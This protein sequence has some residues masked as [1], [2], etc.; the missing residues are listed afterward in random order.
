MESDMKKVGVLAA[1][2]LAEIGFV[3]DLEAFFNSVVKLLEN[4]TAGSV[5]PWVTEKLYRR[6]LKENELILVKQQL[7]E[8]HDIF[9]SSKPSNVNLVDMGLV[10]ENTTFDM[11]AKNLSTLFKRVFEAYAEA[12]ECSV[13]YRQAFNEYIP[14]RLGITDA[15][16]YINDVNRPESEYESLDNHSLPFWLIE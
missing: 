8:I 9:S 3:S 7:D 4:D 14:V 15:P 10:I 2:T 5:Y 6:S 13:V 11:N 12:L 16:Y 1:M